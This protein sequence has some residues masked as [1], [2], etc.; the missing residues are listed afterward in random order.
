MD[1]A[2]GIFR[3]VLPEPGITRTLV[4]V[5]FPYLLPTVATRTAHPT[6]L[7]YG[8]RL[9]RSRAYL[10]FT[11]Y[12]AQR[13]RLVALSFCRLSQLFV[14]GQGVYMLVG[15]SDSYPTVN[16]RGLGVFAH[17]VLRAFPNQKIYEL[18]TS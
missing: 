14:T 11:A 9:P 18:A 8:P 7:D 13:R 17:I 12:K 6:R 3:R 5:G 4:T 1:G 10:S 2:A 16:F 15:S